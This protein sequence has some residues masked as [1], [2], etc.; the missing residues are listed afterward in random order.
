MPESDNVIVSRVKG[1]ADKV[2]E[3]PTCMNFCACG[4]A[5]KSGLGNVGLTKAMVPLKGTLNDET[6]EIGDLPNPNRP[7][8]NSTRE[9]ERER[10]C[11]KRGI[12]K[13]W[14]RAPH[15]DPPCGGW[16]R[17]EAASASAAMRRR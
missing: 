8:P 6:A 14:R 15:G 1:K 2:A 7:S 5:L 10:P 12:V 17:P 3:A 4:R 11:R 9:G 16:T 13:T